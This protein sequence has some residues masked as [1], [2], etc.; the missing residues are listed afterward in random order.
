MG[1]GICDALKIIKKKLKATVASTYE[2]IE[3][4]L[5]N[6]LWHDT[7]LSMYIVRAHFPCVKIVHKEKSK[8]TFASIPG[9]CIVF[10]FR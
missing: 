7:N 2:N 10:T 1:N 3:V 4:N 5:F 9:C 6:F 8:E